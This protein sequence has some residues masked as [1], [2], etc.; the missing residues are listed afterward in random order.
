LAAPIDRLADM[1]RKFPD[2]DDKAGTK[3]WGELWRWWEGKGREI[4]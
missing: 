2:E 3:V 4:G 1:F